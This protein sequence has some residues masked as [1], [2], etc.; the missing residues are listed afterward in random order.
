MAYAVWRCLGILAGSQAHGWLFAA[1]ARS[2]C[3]G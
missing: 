2:N 1:I 3:V